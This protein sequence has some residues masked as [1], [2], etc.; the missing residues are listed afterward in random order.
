M[1]KFFLKEIVIFLLNNQF[2]FMSR[3]STT[4]VLY[5]LQNL[6][7]KYFFLKKDLHMIFI[8]KYDGSTI[9]VMT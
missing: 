2:D 6:I 4:E 8:Y 3:K 5:I 7:E 1:I 9:S